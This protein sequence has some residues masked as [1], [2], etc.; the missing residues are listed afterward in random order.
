M[1]ERKRFLFASWDGGGNVP[2]ML[3]MV[4]RLV[5]RGHDVRVIGDACTRAEAEA[6]GAAFRSWRHA[7]SRPDHGIASDPLRDWE[8]TDPLD[9]LRRI[10]AH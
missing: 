1:T 6:A 10:I 3:T 5:A 4:R 2:P 9:V 7:P 8:S